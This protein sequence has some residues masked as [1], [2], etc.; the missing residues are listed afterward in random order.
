MSHLLE[1]V[2][3]WDGKERREIPFHLV[4]YMDEKLKAHTAEIKGI[5]D[6][7]TGDEM[8]RYQEILGSVGD[9]K[10]DI[11][12]RFRSVLVEMEERFSALGGSIDAYMSDVEALYNA[13]S[14]AF[15]KDEDGKPDFKGH[16]KDHK[17]RMENAEKHEQLMAYV[18]QQM[19]NDKN[20]AEDRRFI[21][22]AVIGGV[23]TVFVLWAAKVLWY[24]AVQTAKNPVVV[25]QK[26]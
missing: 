26:K 12:S 15:P 21:K 25:E 23:V 10:G 4:N 18:D 16:A 3:E 19:K 9:I 22:R 8:K 11:E 2:P 5:V 20:N 17:I 6:G 1:P 14:Q 7:H 24:D 13:V